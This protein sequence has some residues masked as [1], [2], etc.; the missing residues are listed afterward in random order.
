MKAR[1]LFVL[2]VILG[3][4]ALGV[5]GG[6]PAAQA[7]QPTNPFAGAWSGEYTFYFADGTPAFGGTVEWTVSAHGVLLGAVDSDTEFE[8]TLRGH[9][10][11]NG[12]VIIVNPPFGF[13]TPGHASI[14]DDGQMETTLVNPWPDGF[15]IE[16]VMDPV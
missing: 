15:T 3:T 13:P 5:L 8:S 6:S 4:L 7:A 12:Q 14:N 1:C 9:V 16:T 11:P 2:A 10:D